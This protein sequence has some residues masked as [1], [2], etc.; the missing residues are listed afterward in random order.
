[1]IARTGA[2][3]RPAS[4][5]TPR[6]L[7]G[8]SADYWGVR[9]LLL[10]VGAWVAGLFLGFEQALTILTVAGFVA[11]VVGVVHPTIGLLGVAILSTLDAPMRHFLMTGGWLRWNTFNYW[12][13]VVI[14][15]A[16]PFISRLTDWHTRILQ[17]L[18]LLLGLEVLIAPDLEAGLQ[19]LLNGVA[20]LGLLAY[21]APA[22]RSRH[23]W[24]WLGITCG[25]LGAG[26]GLVYYLQR[27]QLEAINAN[28]WSLFPTTALF[29]ICL[30]FSAAEAYRRGQLVLVLLAGLNFVWVFLSGSRGNML[31][32]A[33]CILLLVAA[34]R[35]V[36]SRVVALAAALLVGLWVSTYF[37]DLQEQ[38]LFRIEKLFNARY[39]LTSRT[40]GR[41]D[42]AMG[43][44]Y[45]FL[46]HPMGV[47]TGG[48]GA[49]W[50]ELDF[51]SG[52]SG[53]ARGRRFAAHSAWL[54]VLVENGIPGLVLLAAFVGSFAV[55][56]W[57]TRRRELALVGMLV[58][59]T[60]TTAW[61][62]TEFQSK[63]LWF[64]AAGAITLLNRERVAAAVRGGGS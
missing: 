4:G 37:T 7:T 54:K 21:F 33:G 43:G 14:V 18:F 39:A 47:G 9:F 17:L 62:S 59:L 61:L 29:A 36:R 58:T 22:S 24:Y 12:L 50:Q 41:V 55:V 26:G 3:G 2:L 16:L 5:V 31:I 10:I 48:F 11:A 63:G 27:Q 42:V 44:W 8:G 6:E 1:M 23:I 46:E 64:L 28:A 19:H 13:L 45:M 51:R 57:R 34:I 32:A 49:G 35:G 20:V 30:G 56:G 53:F 38:A 25:V 15:L 52:F 40:S 60:F